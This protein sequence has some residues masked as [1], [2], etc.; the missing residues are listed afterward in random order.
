VRDL[1]LPPRCRWS[2]RYSELLSRYVGRCLPTFGT[3]YRSHLQRSSS[4][5][6]GLKLRLQPRRAQA[7]GV[8]SW[9]QPSIRVRTFLTDGQYWTLCYFQILFRNSFTFW[10]GKTNSV[11]EGR[12]VTFGFCNAV[13]SRR[14]KL[15]KLADLFLD[16][17][18]VA[19]GLHNAILY[20]FYWCGRGWGVKS[21]CGSCLLLTLFLNS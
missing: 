21:W 18:D 4:P 12:R 10:P 20:S 17:A 5:R 14:N 7:S 19:V 1:V 3:A 15:S 8:G 13:N 2:L 16:A 9:L 6:L 11:L